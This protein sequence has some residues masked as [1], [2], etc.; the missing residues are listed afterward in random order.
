MSELI[1]LVKLQQ[2]L[3]QGVDA[4]VE[5]VE[6]DP[7]NPWFNEYLDIADRCM[8]LERDISSLTRELLQAAQPRGVG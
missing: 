3:R 2:D 7:E 4:L 5:Q 1:R 6:I 8:R